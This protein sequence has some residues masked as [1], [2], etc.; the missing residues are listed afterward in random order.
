ML[1][2]ELSGASTSPSGTEELAPLSQLPPALLNVLIEDESPRSD[3]PVWGYR[4]PSSWRS[5]IGPFSPNGN[6]NEGRR[7]VAPY[8]REYTRT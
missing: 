8:W 4:K 5:I 1:A 2:S 7:S 3:L 6:L